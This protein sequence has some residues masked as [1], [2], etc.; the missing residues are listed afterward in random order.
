MTRQ[1]KEKKLELKKEQRCRKSKDDFWTFCLWMDYSFFKSRESF[2]K[3]IAET[4][5]HVYNGDIKR[6]AISLPPRSGK[7][8]IISL[9]IA[10]WFG[11]DQ[12]YSI[13]RNTH[14][15]RLS[16]KFS[17]DIKTI[18]KSELYKKAFGTLEFEK[19]AAEDWKLKGS[20][21]GIS[22]FCAGVGGNVTGFGC[23]G[24]A[25]LDDSI[26]NFEE[27]NSDLQLEKKWEWYT[28]VH[29]QRIEGEAP[30][31]HIGTRWSSS[32]IMG[33]TEELG[34]YDKIIKVPAIINGETFCSAVKT[35]EQY[36]EDKLMLPEH[37]FEA[38]LMQNP[39]E[40]KGRLY[41]LNELNRFTL[42]EIKNQVPD[43][44][45]NVTDTADEGTDS[46]CSPI[47][48]LYG[49]KVYITDVIFTTD[50]IEVTRP[51]V[52]A[53]LDRHHVKKARFESNN[54]GKGF[55][56]TVKR[57]LKGNT[58]VSWK[59]T[60]KN[61]HTRII[62]ES[63]NIKERF[64]FRSDIVPGSDYWSYLDELCRYKKSGGNKHDDAPDGTTMMSELTTNINGIGFL[65]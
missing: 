58:S 21:T 39:I 56:Q 15:A 52:A 62:M 8:Y 1:K 48:Y 59:P 29:K 11:K 32:D 27:A 30:E 63:P 23:D 28:G 61:K 41:N 7:S 51:L 57:L 40:V 24:V 47:G 37:I 64:Y 6:L 4:L 38:E 42:D 35:T 54:G 33:K 53:M 2:I 20:K 55:A 44:I 25:I 5:Q 34:L 49:D 46:L 18:I 43:G 45:V 50:P 16:I 13:M 22:Y 60:V 10:W 36:M 17:N 31:I 26:K 12:S 19:D 65:T 3:D 9:F 14:T